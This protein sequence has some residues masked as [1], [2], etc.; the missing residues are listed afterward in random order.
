MKREETR[1]EGI[2]LAS[3]SELLFRLM[4]DNEDCSPD[5]TFFIHLLNMGWKIIDDVPETMHL[6]K[7]G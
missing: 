6:L 4:Y 3:R 2:R 5:A 1:C 7:E